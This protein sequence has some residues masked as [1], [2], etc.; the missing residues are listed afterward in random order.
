MTT[1][2][3]AQS[4]AGGLRCLPLLPGDS[5]RLAPIIR[6][7]RERADRLGQYVQDAVPA[8]TPPITTFLR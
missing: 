3:T 1:L 8:A 4:E 5:D 6:D 7:W 2:P